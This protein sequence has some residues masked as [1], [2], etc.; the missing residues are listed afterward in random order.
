MAGVAEY[1]ELI[2]PAWEVTLMSEFQGW[3]PGVRRDVSV[4]LLR[5]LIDVLHFYRRDLWT[6]GPGGWRRANRLHRPEPWI[7][8]RGEYRLRLV[9]PQWALPERASL[10]DLITALLRSVGRILLALGDQESLEVFR[11]IV[12]ARDCA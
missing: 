5:W 10:A 2:L 9:L 3:S 12:V 6:Y 4:S 8:Q 11:W 1:E 7:V